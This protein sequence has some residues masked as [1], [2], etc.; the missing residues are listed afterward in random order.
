MSLHQTMVVLRAL[1]LGDFLTVIPALRGLR[2]RFPNHVLYLTCPVW[3]RPLVEFTGLVDELIDGAPG[4]KPKTMASEGRWVPGDMRERIALE[5]AQL[6]GIIGVPSNP[7]VAV[8]LR[9]VRQELIRVLLALRPRRL[10][11]FCN[12]EVPETSCG[13][14]WRPDEHEV[15][16][17]CR[18]LNENGIPADPGDLHVSVPDSYAPAIARGTTLIHPGAG[19]PAR[20]WPVERWATVVRREVE[21]GRSV[22]ISGGPHEVQL[23]FDVAARAGLGPERVLAGHTDALQLTA[24][25]QVADRVVC[26]DTGIAHLA[27]A[28]GTPSVVLFGP[29]PPSRWGPPLHLRAKHRVLWAGK[30]GE[31]YAND[32]DPGLL[33]ITVRDVL[34]ELQ[35][36]E[37][38][39]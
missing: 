21:R 13:P 36:L 9:G 16:R 20:C 35:N 25:I 15:E 2:A 8:N 7:D 27:V 29:M 37:S 38:L 10:I 34:S 14:E 4:N 17:Y 3:L 22:V 39:S 19:S 32:P 12:P 28:V 1:A 30:E 5:Q 33:S 6:Q 11:S 26:S 18:L 24:A 31:P 23:A